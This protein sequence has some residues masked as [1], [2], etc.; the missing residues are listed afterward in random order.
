MSINIGGIVGQYSDIA[1]I[2]SYV[3]ILFYFLFASILLII[4]IRG[5][6][7]INI[8]KILFFIILFIYLGILILN[9]YIN[10]DFF[11]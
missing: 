10:I 5:T 8:N 6:K 9:K 3:G 7:I 4:F 2:S 1:V 11:D